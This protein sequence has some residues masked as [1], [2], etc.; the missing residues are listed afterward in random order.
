[1]Y[2]SDHPDRFSW[3]HYVYWW[4]PHKIGPFS[5]WYHRTEYDE[6]RRRGLAVYSVR[7]NKFLWEHHEGKLPWTPVLPARVYRKIA[8]TSAVPGSTA[9]AAS[10]GTAAADPGGSAG[11]DVRRLVSQEVLDLPGK[12]DAKPSDDKTGIDYWKQLPDDVTVEELAAMGSGTL[13]L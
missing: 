11:G 10:G 12:V 1:M 9:A 5:N 3:E 2:A 4:T 7:A 13:L 8:T 6:W